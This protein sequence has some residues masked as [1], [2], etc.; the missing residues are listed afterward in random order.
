MNGRWVQLDNQ[1]EA[2]RRRWENGECTLDD[3]GRLIRI[4]DEL[5]RDLEYQDDRRLHQEKG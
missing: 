5:R 3:V 1:V 4:V 2:V